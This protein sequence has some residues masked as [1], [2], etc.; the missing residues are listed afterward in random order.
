ML[1]SGCSC[2]CRIYKDQTRTACPPSTTEPGETISGTD[3]MHGLI[4]WCERQGFECVELNDQESKL[5]PRRHHQLC[6]PERF[7]G[8]TA[9]SSVITGLE[10]VLEKLRTL[11]PRLQKNGLRESS[12]QG[13]E[14]CQGCRTRK[15]ATCR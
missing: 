1:A 13:D 9:L 3:T 2:R 10:G 8:L 11:G 15:G 7:H 12:P 4:G 14:H 5:W 6:V